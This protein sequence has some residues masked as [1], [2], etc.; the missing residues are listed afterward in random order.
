MGVFIVRSRSSNKCFLEATSDLRAR[1]NGVLARLDGNMHPN[2]ELQK[3][4]NELG[5]DNFTFEILE[6]L[7]YDKD[8]TK[9]DYS[10][11]LLLL[12]MIWEEKLIKQGME[13]YKKRL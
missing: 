12:Q 10:E 9:A 2:R 5:R 11:E 6:E 4:W 1:F 3:E 13:F 8:E 7:A